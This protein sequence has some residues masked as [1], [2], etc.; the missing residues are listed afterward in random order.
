VGT[1]K[2]ERQKANRQ[3]RLEEL[4]RQQVRQKRK[5]T[6]TIWGGIG[7]LA[8]L[9]AFLIWFFNRDNSNTVATSD[10]SV[11]AATTTEP[12]PN[13]TSAASTV[14]G[15]TTVPAPFAYGTGECPNPDGSSP[16]TTTFTA[17]PKLC[18][19][20]TKTYTAMIETN[21]GSFTAVLDAAKAPG[22][23]NNFITLA[24]YHYFDSTPCHRIIAGFVV[25]CGDPT[26]KGTGGPGY[27]VAD[28][29]PQAG[30]YKIGSLAMANSGPNTNG[31]Q[32]FVITGDQGAQL[33]PNYSLFGQVT[34]GL[35]TTVK[36][37][38][39]AANP[40]PSANGVPPKEPISISKVTI[41]ES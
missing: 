9:V 28:E 17:A 21:K 39:A 13:A 6:V 22:T 35:D 7:V 26:G 27:T 34:D 30:E 31:S 36:A 14:P 8:V 23:V 29:L 1:E 20:P 11:V 12:P 4:Q 19:D 3:I 5:R 18:I 24:R 37:L 25:Q 40:D 15:V 41:T 2:R 38:D 10:T 33:P 32:F 16:K